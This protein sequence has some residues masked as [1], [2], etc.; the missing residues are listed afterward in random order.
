MKRNGKNPAVRPVEGIYEKGVKLSKK[1]MKEY[2]ELIERM[3]RL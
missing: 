1:I 2:E 3:D